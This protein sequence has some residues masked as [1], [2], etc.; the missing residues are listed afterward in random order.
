MIKE[1]KERYEEEKARKRAELEASLEAGEIGDPISTILISMAVSAAISA[2]SYFVSAALAPKPPRQKIGAISGTL[3]LQNSE[4]G[5]FIPEIYGASPSVTLVTGADPTYQNVANA[6]AGG[7]GSITKTG[8]GTAWNAGAT[9]NTAITAGQDAFFQF[10]VG[11][12]YAAAGFTL[13]ASPTNGNTDFLFGIQWNTDNS[14]TVRW[15]SSQSVANVTHWVTGDVFRLELRSGRFRL[16]KGSAELTPAGMVSPTPSYPLYMGIA[17]QTVGAGIS[18]AKVKIDAIGVAPNAGRGGVK[19]P[20]IIVWSSGIRKNVTTTTTQSSG[21]KGFGGGGSQTVDNI[22][23][24]IDLGLMFGRGPLTLLREYGN[25]DIL[26][27]QVTQ[28]AN[29]SGVYDPDVGADSTYDPTAPP[30][31]NVNY[32]TA[33]DRVD[34]DIPVDGDGVGS[35]TIQGGSSSFTIYPGNTTQQPDPTIEADVDGRYGLGST[36]AYRNHAL[37][38]H[39]RLSMSRWGGTVPNIT[40]VWEHESLKTLDDIFASMCERVDVKTANSDYD[41]TGLSTIESRGMLVAGRPFQPAEL[42]DSDEI[43][44]AYNY[45]VTEREGQVVGFAEGAEP[46]VTIADTE[47]GWL[48]GDEELPDVLPE[49]DSMLAPEIS[50]PREVHVK[51]IDPDQDWE[52]NTQSAIRQ[53]TDGHAVELLEVQ[54]TQLS[55]ERRAMAQRALYKRYV[56]GTAHKF[57]LP[58]TYLYLFPGYKIVITRAEG[59]THTLRLTSMVGGVGVLDCEGIA[60][61]SEVFNQ[62]ANGVFPPGYIPP[63]PIPAMTIGVFLDTPLLRDGDNNVNGGVGFYAGGV[64]RTGVNQNWQGFVLYVERNG[65]WVVIGNSNLPAT[66]GTV[67]SVSGATPSDPSVIDRTTTITL[68]LYGTTAT[69][70]SITEADANADISKNVAVV[71]NE[72]IRFLT[73]T[74][75]A[76]YPNRWTISNLYRGQRGTEGY[77]GDTLTNKRFVLIDNAI[78]FI[79]MDVADLGSTYNYRLVSVGQSLGDAAIVSFVWTGGVLKPLSPV[80]VRGIRDFELSLVIEWTRRARIGEGL[81]VGSD[82]P[83]A[84]EKEKYEVDIYSGA[85]VVRTIHCDPLDPEV[86]MWQ[87]EYYAT[88]PVA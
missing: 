86:P 24:D 10:T 62:P 52:P 39:N 71:N 47:I 33:F 72:V 37:I 36:P 8:G 79:P 2:A 17:M 76:D 9:H 31:P 4:Q 41:F 82:V 48:D 88:G 69:L 59:F 25:A 29:P 84:E 28:T 34:A 27:D 3:Q 81:R 38:V 61:E 55:D 80:N 23:Y 20:A 7:S 40:A 19:V 42:I 66:I 64:P 22:S 16:Y 87:L 49:V 56:A 35:G 26:I 73:A 11:T 50:F 70:S 77:V 83:I 53:I 30:D 75:V 58:W 44:L 67:V 21:G 1:F 57:T 12:G 18:A 63:Q 51:S 5:I 54:I 43:K 32:L 85:N 46:T 13:T 74:Q 68:D 65:D 60:L 45:F 15:S 14:V 78:Q 6:T